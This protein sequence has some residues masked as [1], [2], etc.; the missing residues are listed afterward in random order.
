MKVLSLPI[1][2]LG[3]FRVCCTEALFNLVSWIRHTWTALDGKS[4][5]RQLKSFRKD[6]ILAT[7]RAPYTLRQCWSRSLPKDALEKYLINIDAAY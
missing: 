3:V 2:I 1:A 6:I 5:F 4:A 7:M